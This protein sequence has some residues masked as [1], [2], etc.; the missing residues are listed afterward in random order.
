ESRL[1][2]RQ[3]GIRQRQFLKRQVLKQPIDPGVPPERESNTVLKPTLVAEIDAQIKDKEAELLTVNNKRRDRVAQVDADARRLREEFDRRSG[4]KR[5]D[6]DRKREAL[7]ASQAAL[8]TQ[9]V[10]EE[11]QIEQEYESVAQKVDGYR[12]EIDACR[13]KAEGF[14]EAREA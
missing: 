5:E 11:K 7:L 13:K 4:T 9:W 1:R 3:G 12:A 2:K 14:Y 10:A 8:A 6:T